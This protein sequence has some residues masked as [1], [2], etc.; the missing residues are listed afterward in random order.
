MN[1]SPVLAELGTYP[2]VRLDEAKRRLAERGARVIDFG[3][4]DPREPTAPLIRQALV[5]GI[6]ETIGEVAVRARTEKTPPGKLADRMVEER[7][8]AARV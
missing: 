7:L 1:V 2:F 4:G 5:D 8:S 6:R 3:V